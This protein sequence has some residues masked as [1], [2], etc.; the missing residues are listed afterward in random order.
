MGQ[1]DADKNRLSHTQEVHKL[2][3]RYVL[4]SRYPHTHTYTHQCCGAAGRPEVRLWKS[5]LIHEPEAFIQT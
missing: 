1:S 2:S 5:W 4:I 3:H